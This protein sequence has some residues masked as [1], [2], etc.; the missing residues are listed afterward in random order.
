MESLDKPPAKGYLKRVEMHARLPL[1]FDPGTSFVYHLGFPVIG[2]VIEIV[3]E[4]TLEEFYQERIFK[5]LGMKDT[6]F[7]LD[8]KKLNRF[9]TCYSPD[10][11][12]GKRSLKIYDRA[13]T[14]EKV[15]G[16]GK[17]HG[18]GGDMGGL[19]STAGD[20]ARFGQMLLN[21]GELDGVRILGRKSVE[22]M[23]SNHLKDIT[24]L[25]LAPGFGF[26]LGVGVYKGTS[27]L[28]VYRSPGTFGWGG[29][30]GTT[31]FAD[32]K[33]GLMA[34]C[35]TQMF[36]APMAPGNF[37]EEFERVVYQALL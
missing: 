37:Q 25:F 22:I 3:T 36:G 34:L 30:A 13:E 31:F 11:T 12:K 28:P 26:G 9:T 10:M 17:I 1:N 33:E 27:P 16:T 20:Y 19:L 7:Y 35:F 23:T 32:P 6:S 2:A 29:A 14:S 15:K 4:K 21:G 24:T 18:A 5:P 8:K